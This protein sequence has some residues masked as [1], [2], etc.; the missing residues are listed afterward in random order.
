MPRAATPRFRVEPEFETTYPGASRL[1]TECVLNT[2]YIADRFGAYVEALVRRRGIPSMAAFNALEVVRGAGEPLPPSVIAERMV[3]SRGTMTSILDSLE[4]RGL[5]RRVRHERDRRM[6]RVIVT[7][8]GARRAL[9]VLPELH[10]AEQRWLACLTPN[11][12]R[13]LLRLVAIL[14][15]HLPAR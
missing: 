15:A 14:E 5:I 2:G 10:A 11:Q 8:E 6:R 7:D 1:A 4:R 3:L 9:A 13:M 12:Q